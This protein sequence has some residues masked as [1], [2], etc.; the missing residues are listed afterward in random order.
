MAKQVS[1]AGRQP[2]SFVTEGLR[3]DRQVVAGFRTGSGQFISLAEE[4]YQEL[5]IPRRKIE[6]EDRFLN[7]GSDRPVGFFLQ[8]AGHPF[9]SAAYIISI[10]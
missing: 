6:L 10:R 1:K 9:D 3:M 2:D 4:H 8:V 5:G 7:E